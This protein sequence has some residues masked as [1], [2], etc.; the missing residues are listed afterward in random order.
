MFLGDDGGRSFYQDIF[1]SQNMMKNIK[2]LTN[3]RK[4]EL[5]SFGIK[6]LSSFCLKINDEIKSI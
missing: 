3:D 5:L 4:V 1:L 6:Q 2:H